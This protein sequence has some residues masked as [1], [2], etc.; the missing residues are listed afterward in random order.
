MKSMAFVVNCARKF[1]CQMFV[2][3]FASF[4]QTQDSPYAQEFKKF[5]AEKTKKSDRG[6][7]LCLHLPNTTMFLF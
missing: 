3:I 6:S 4:A 2:V 1:V 5:P 7:H